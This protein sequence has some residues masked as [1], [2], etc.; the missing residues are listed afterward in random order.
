MSQ[1]P[2]AYYTLYPRTNTTPQAPANANNQRAASQ[3]AAEK[4]PEKKETLISRYNLEQRIA[5][6]EAEQ[7]KEEEIGG[8]A[9]WEDT[10]EKREASLRERKAKMILAARQ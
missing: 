2:A 4:Q 9:A 6:G 8:R 10:A 5:S 1:P 7:I 3:R